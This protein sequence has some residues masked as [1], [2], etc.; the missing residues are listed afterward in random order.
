M[1]EGG[2]FS[3]GLGKKGSGAEEITYQFIMTNPDGTV[4]DPA[5]IPSVVRIS[6]SVT[7]QVGD[8]EKGSYIYTDL[9][10]WRGR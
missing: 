7:W 1:D 5:D 3:P 2:N 4:I 8:Q 6:V 9:S 10:N